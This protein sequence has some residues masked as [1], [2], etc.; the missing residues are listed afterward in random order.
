MSE[1]KEEIIN[2]L[3]KIVSNDD[4]VLIGNLKCIDD[5]CTLFLTDVVEV[6]DKEGDFY[7]PNVLY[8][9]NNDNIF[10][11]ESE[12]NYYQIYSPSI[13]PKNQIKKIY[14]LG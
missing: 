8:K 4:R 6:F 2:K 14:M 10:G 13:I 3:V 1:N 5:S 9:N 12:K 11:F 7:V